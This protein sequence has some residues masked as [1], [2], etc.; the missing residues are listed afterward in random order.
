MQRSVK[1]IVNADS[2]IPLGASSPIKLIRWER[3]DR[4]SISAEDQ[5]A[6]DGRNERNTHWAENNVLSIDGDEDFFQCL[7]RCIQLVLL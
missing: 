1:M 4:S 5:L 3:S 2:L 7:F 6:F